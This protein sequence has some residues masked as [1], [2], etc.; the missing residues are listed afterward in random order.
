M[1]FS[2]G[3][4]LA[5]ADAVVTGLGH[6]SSTLWQYRWAWSR[7]EVFCGEYDVAELTDEVV[8]GFLG[9]VAAEHGEGRI[10][11]W[12]RKLLRKAMLVLSEVALTGTYTW[13]VTRGRHRNDGLTAVF[14]PV[15]EQFEQWLTGQGV[16][17][18][19]A[20]LYATVS[21]KV[22]TWLPERGV[23]DVRRLSA[24]D[25]SAAVVF[26]GASYSPGSMRTVLTA[27]RVWCRF[28][29]DTGRC[30][31]LSPAVPAAHCRRVRTVVVLSAD[32]VELV[33]ASPDPATPVGRRDRAMLLLAARTG[34][35]PSDVAGLRL[36]DIDWRQTRITVTQHKTGTV[37]VLPLLADVGAAIAEYL[38]SDRPVDALDDHVF[39]RAQAP[40]VG[41]GCSDL[42][43]VAAGA[44]ARAKTVTTSDTGR[45]MRV[46]RASL[47]TRMLQQDTPLPV[48]SGA[49]GHRGIDSAK[50]YLAG[51]EARMRQCCLDFAGIEPNRARP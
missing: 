15:Q 6:A 13:K 46:L 47:A 31:K 22:L 26:L 40:H 49:L 32:D 12:K 20:A 1:S 17:P 2:V 37:L 38:L 50:H 39:L 34:L 3:V 48:I 45:G 11:E 5:R 21:R 28:L 51:D 30:A 43:H 36:A 14:G 8:A 24:G 35:R 10:K 42:Y 33:V 25:V 18:A 9:W 23:V 41:L 4:V 19:T 16:A 44:F 27:L 29:E 7:V